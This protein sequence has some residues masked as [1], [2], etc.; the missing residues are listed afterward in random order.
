MNVW[1]FVAAVAIASVPLVP[2]P[3][4]VVPA[5]VN[6]YAA[7]DVND[8]PSPILRLPPIVSPTTVV[9]VAVPLKR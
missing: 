4:V 8:V 9:V 2:P 5:T 7:F 6:A 1:V 3:T